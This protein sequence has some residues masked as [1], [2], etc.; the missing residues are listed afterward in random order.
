LPLGLSAGL[1]T[2]TDIS[3]I[4]Q[5]AVAVKRGDAAAATPVDSIG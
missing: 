1:G 5:I 3:Q 2:A 4:D